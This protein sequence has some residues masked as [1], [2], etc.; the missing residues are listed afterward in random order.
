MLTI[1]AKPRSSRKLENRSFL[2][3]MPYAKVM[4]ESRGDT[5]E[6]AESAE[7]N[8]GTAVR[9]GLYEVTEEECD[10]EAKKTCGEIACQSCI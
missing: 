4:P 9:R 3:T 2:A 7:I 1:D 8:A 6:I 5:G 10:V